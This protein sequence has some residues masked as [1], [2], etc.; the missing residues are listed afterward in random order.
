MTCANQ[1]C[2]CIWMNEMDG[3]EFVVL[4][5]T[6]QK[7]SHKKLFI[8]LISFNFIVAAFY[9]VACDVY[10]FSAKPAKWICYRTLQHSTAQQWYC[11]FSLRLAFCIHAQFSAPLL[12]NV[13]NSNW[14][15][16]NFFFCRHSADVRRKKRKWKTDGVSLTGERKHM[17]TY[18]HTV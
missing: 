18:T 16:H 10:A 6:T 3:C 4:C 13:K 17:H 1:I 9:D 5:E 11:E 8:L 7:K 14:L 15:T 2:V 12:W